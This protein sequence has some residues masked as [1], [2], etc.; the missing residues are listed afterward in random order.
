MFAP[1]FSFCALPVHFPDASDG[2]TCLKRTDA[3]HF[4]LFFPPL[5]AQVSP[6]VVI[7]VI[8][9]DAAANWQR[10][11][12][13]PGTTE[14][15]SLRCRRRRWQSSCAHHRCPSSMSGG[16]H[17]SPPLSLCVYVCARVL[18][19]FLFLLFRVH[20]AKALVGHWCTTGETKTGPA[21]QRAASATE[22][23][24]SSSSLS[25]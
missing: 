21:R 10:R 3:P 7:V 12:R 13:C 23:L 9:T 22:E 17:H 16:L 2:K 19:F 25:G 5:A 24:F 11:R 14:R 8:S 4:F 6:V 15:R 1:C 20:W 18:F